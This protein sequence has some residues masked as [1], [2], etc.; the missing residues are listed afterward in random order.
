M[1]KNPRNIHNQMKQC[2][3][4]EEKALE[5]AGLLQRDVNALP[6][7]HSFHNTDFPIGPKATMKELKE[8]YS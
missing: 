6:Q 8:K 2:E 5:S 1:A 7:R 4:V 3:R